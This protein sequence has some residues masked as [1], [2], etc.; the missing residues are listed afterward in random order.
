MY[1]KAKAV[2]KKDAARAFYNKKGQVYLETE[3]SGVGFRG[4]L[5]QMRVGM[6]FPRSEAPHNSHFSQ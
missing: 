1:D 5:L 6:Q 3:V 4:S 2:I